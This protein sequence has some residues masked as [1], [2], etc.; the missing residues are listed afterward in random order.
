MVLVF[1]HSLTNSNTSSRGSFEQLATFLSTQKNV[2]NSYLA[3]YLLKAVAHTMG[4]GDAGGALME[5][6]P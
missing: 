3:D 6:C 5:C 4:D 2:L 1:S